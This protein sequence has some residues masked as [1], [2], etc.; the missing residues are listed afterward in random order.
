MDLYTCRQ[1][2]HASQL[3]L[4]GQRWHRFGT[5]Q[6]QL[7][8]T[9][10]NDAPSAVNDSFVVTEDTPFTGNLLTN[11]SDIEGDALSVTQFSITAL[12]IFTFAA[13][14]TA[15]IPFVGQLTVAS[16]GTFTFTP[17]PN[18]NG[19][20]P[21]FTYTLSDGSLTDT[22][23]LNLSVAAV[24]DA[25]VNNVPGA[26]SVNEDGS[27]RLNGGNRIS[28]GDVDNANLST[29]LSVE[30]GADSERV[31]GRQNHRQWYR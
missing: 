16:D 24:N 11:D 26:Q 13:G 8:I 17:N 7:D 21:Q 30:H 31:P 3:H 19:P 29:T 5:R 18:Y 4:H 20:V 22:A 25:P 10:V 23:T 12:P 27:L 1:R 28:V 2:R 9:P 15:T 6:C 14:S